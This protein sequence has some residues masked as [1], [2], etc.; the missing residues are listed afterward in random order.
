M[1]ERVQSPRLVRRSSEGV[2][3]IAPGTSRWNLGT[4]AAQD[5]VVVS[6]QARQ[7]ATVAGNEQG[8]G[9]QLDFRKL[10]ELAFPSPSRVGAPADSAE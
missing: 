4:G 8:S 7:L 2:H 6:D 10:R 9:L 3:P 1:V 5:R